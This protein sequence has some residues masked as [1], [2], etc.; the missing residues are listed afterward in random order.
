MLMVEPKRVAASAEQPAPMRVI[1]RRLS[2]LPRCRT[3]QM[4]TL[5]PKRVIPI[6]LKEE[7]KRLAVRSDSELPR[8][9]ASRIANVEPKYAFPKTDWM[10]PMRW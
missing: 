1:C 5:L 7:P 9:T 3:S 4:E 6:R 8:W 2:E 10:L